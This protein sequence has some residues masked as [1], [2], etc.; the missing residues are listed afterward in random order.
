MNHS[1]Q[2][3]LEALRNDRVAER[4]QMQE[5]LSRVTERLYEE[6]RETIERLRAATAKMHDQAN[7]GLAGPQIKHAAAGVNE[8]MAVRVEEVEKML[9]ESQGRVFKLDKLAT[10]L[11]RQLEIFQVCNHPEQCGMKST[12]YLLF[13]F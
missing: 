1:Y 5:Q 4:K 8:A 6:N 12:H 2:D 10:S 11:K 9:T 7:N 13:S 3:Q